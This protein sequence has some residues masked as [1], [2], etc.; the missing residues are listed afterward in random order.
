MMVRAF[1]WAFLVPILVAGDDF[2]KDYRGLRS[3]KAIRYPATAV[4]SERKLQANGP[5]PFEE[6]FCPR[7]EGFGPSEA[8]SPAPVLSPSQ[9][10]KPTLL[11]LTTSPTSGPTSGPSSTP[12][13]APA[14]GMPTSSTGSP[15]TATSAPTKSPT[16]VT[17][18]NGNIVDFV[19]AKP[20]LSFL[21][22]VVERTG[23]DDDTFNGPGP[24]TLFAPTNNAFTK[25]RNDFSDITSLL[26]NENE[27]FLPHLRD[28][29][30]YHVLD[31][32]FF[33]SDLAASM[34]AALNGEKVTIS[35]DPLGVN[36]ITISDRDNQVNNGVVHTIDTDV[37][38][39]IWVFN[40]V[41]DRVD[42][43]SDLS[44]FGRLLVMASESLRNTTGLNLTQPV[45]LTLLAPTNDAFA[46]VP[47]DEL[48]FLTN[49][50]NVADL[51]TLLSYHIIPG[52]FTLDSLLPRQQL[53]T[54]EGRGITFINNA[55]NT[56]T[57]S[58]RFNNAGV[59]ERDILAKNGV[60]HTIDAVLDFSISLGTFVERDSELSTFFTAIRRAGFLRALSGRGD[61][62]LFAPVDSAFSDLPPEILDLLFNK[63]DFIPHLQ[64]FVFNHLLPNRTFAADFINGTQEL[65]LSKEFLNVRLEPF[66]VNE[67]LVN[68]TDND[69]SNG[70]AL[71]IGGVLSPS[72]VTNRLADRVLAEADLSKLLMLLTSAA[73]D[74]SGPGGFTLFAPT[75]E[76]F[77]KNPDTLEA[78]MVPDN[79]E[80][81]PF[82]NYHLAVGVFTL[83]NLTGSSG[84]QL[85]TRLGR[86]VTVIVSQPR[87]IKDTPRLSINTAAVLDV[88]VKDGDDVDDRVGKDV[89]ILASN[90]VLHKL[91]ELLVPKQLVFNV[92]ADDS[93]LTEFSTAIAR[94]GLLET[95]SMNGTITLFA[96]TNEAFKGIETGLL[97][98]LLF[99]KEFL[100][101]LKDFL[102]Y[103]FVMGAVLSTGSVTTLNGESVTIG[104][105]PTIT[106][107]GIAASPAI[108]AT[109][110]VV[111]KID[112]V[113]MPSW[114]ANSLLTRTQSNTNLTLLLNLVVIADFDILDNS[115]GELTFLAATNAAFDF[116]P[117]NIVTRLVDPANSRSLARLLFYNILVPGILTL[118]ELIPGAYATLE[119]NT[120]NV[121]RANGN[122][123]IM[124]NKAKLLGEPILANN[125]IFYEVDTVLFPP[126]F[127]F[128]LLQSSNTVNTTASPGLG[129]F[130]EDLSSPPPA[131]TG[132]G[133]LVDA[134]LN[135]PNPRFG[136]SEDT[137]S[138]AFGG[139]STADDGQV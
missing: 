88:G 59:V 6:P 9:P 81:V 49:P 7:Q 17:T 73:I 63:T 1:T 98:K 83:V 12:T 45:A 135:A 14:T 26:C 133:G 78:L 71:K 11:S 68:G 21:L 50:D 130:S 44:T 30:L 32:K 116:I 66:R 99:N 23:L 4:H 46:A 139:F 96:P 92:V 65:A 125:G 93:N 80:L 124:F 52:V 94:A 86:S 138:P 10:M 77:E 2:L 18:F 126:D 69:Q 22:E 53:P 64:Q 121:K 106:V 110:G 29:L 24:L 56:N 34:P 25:F 114:V 107:D 54:F 111:Q 102:R 67:A 3:Q 89:D 122:S 37:L 120:I 100:P 8:P 127:F 20:T 82:L 57:N 70:V 15:T 27:Q 75:N 112:S 36:N 118:E 87:D 119:G 84:L 137:E 115:R 48:D 41:V 128:M 113:L 134:F 85:P 61:F 103:H 91:S 13:L 60:V 104:L 62:T 117:D 58:F 35:L 47:Q 97:V 105:N 19:K 129:G 42:S 132:I 43:K 16:S 101:H 95:L 33:A 55:S 51:V 136:G 72:W 79:D 109:N 38:T 90:G 5:T 40:T 108:N 28:L 31:G 39:P 74:L 76:A 123:S 131:N